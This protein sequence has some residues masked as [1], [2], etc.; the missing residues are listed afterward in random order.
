M[1]T[2]LQVREQLTASSPSFV[3]AVFD[4]ASTL[5]PATAT[6]GK[7]TSK[8][9]NDPIWKVIAL[10]K[11]E[12]DICELPLMQRLRRVRQL[13]LGY[14]V[15]PS[16]HHSRFEHSL[17]AVFAATRMF[18]Q[19][20][21]HAK[22]TEQELN[23]IF[24]TVRLAALLHDCGHS[25]FS[26][27]GE[28]VLNMLYRDDI[29]KVGAKLSEIFKDPLQGTLGGSDKPIKPKDPAAAEVIAALLLLSKPMEDFLGRCLPIAQNVAPQDA[30]INTVALILGKPRGLLVDRRYHHW[31][32]GIVSGDLD[33]DKL[34]YVAR[35]AYFAGMPVSAD[36]MRLLSQLASAVMPKQALEPG[37]TADDVKLAD[38]G[39]TR[40]LAL[41]PSGVSAFEMFVMTRSYLFDRLYGHHKTRAAERLMQRL[42][43][44]YLAGAIED[45]HWTQKEVLAFL[46]MPGGDDAAL[47]LIAAPPQG[48]PRNPD[49]EKM[50]QQILSRDLPLRAVQIS[51]RFC[52]E[53]AVRK[54]AATQSSDDFLITPWTLLQQDLMLG[55]DSELAAEIARITQL[56]PG[57]DFILDPP[58]GSPI[59]EDPEVVVSTTGSEDVPD[60]VNKHFDAEQL[61]N[62]YRDI[63]RAA[64]V[65]TSRPHQVL[66]AAGT[67]AALQKLFDIRIHPD[68]VQVAKID[69]SPYEEQLRKLRADGQL[70]TEE[71]NNLLENDGNGRII[72]PTDKLLSTALHW[73]AGEGHYQAAKEKLREQLIAAKVPRAYYH[74]YLL[75]LAVLR[76]LLKH[77]HKYW[78]AKEFQDHQRY[79]NERRF[80]AHLMAF[81]R[82]E[83]PPDSGYEVKEGE[84]N[85]AGITDVVVTQKAAGPGVRAHSVVVELKSEQSPYLPMVEN[86]SGQPQQYAEKGYSPISILYCLFKDEAATS[87]ADTIQVRVPTNKGSS[88]STVCLGI[89]GFSGTA[90]A[91]G[92]THSPQVATAP[93]P[94]APPPPAPTPA[95]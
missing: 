91:G 89:R 7:K 29:S 41:R 59:K 74:D 22:E 42:L 35:D 23:G 26:H 3:G 38:I 54:T 62:A 43:A 72:F 39:E 16:V 82:E 14:L 75:V 93:S 15:F 52:T 71:L 45:N 63:K 36:V 6:G 83:F 88:L 33:A 81:L 24:R 94:S 64:W 17:G 55:D 86:H 48:A 66:V 77:A 79:Q 68:A 19:L 73:V 37:I 2:L 21:R 58:A 9:F 10:D 67:A 51:Q 30:I 80:Q 46:Y 47:E 12:L 34:D 65:F 85:A 44:Y 78:R 90:S 13:G 57:L 25:V 28:R 20:S 49:A 50:A 60:A 84:P 61:S 31:V 69:R 8:D 32:R 18:D 56:D 11:A 27:V 95:P 40:V 4:L 76:A 1:L 92:L 70:S 53:S 5:I 87:I